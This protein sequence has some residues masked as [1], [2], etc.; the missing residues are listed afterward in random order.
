VVVGRKGQ[1]TFN[2]KYRG[3]KTKISKEKVEAEGAKRR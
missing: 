1:E 3:G 2:R